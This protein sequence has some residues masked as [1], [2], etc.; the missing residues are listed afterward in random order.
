MIN[1][2]TI[3]EAF[4]ISSNP[5]QTK[6]I[7][8]SEFNSII[9]RALSSLFY[10]AINDY[11]VDQTWSEILGYFRREEDS[12]RTNNVFPFPNRSGKTELLEA[13]YGTDYNDVTIVSVSEWQDAR[14]RKLDGPTQE[15]PIAMLMNSGY[16]V[17]PIPNRVRYTFLK[18]PVDPIWGFTLSGTDYIY[19]PATSTDLEWPEA[20]LDRFVDRLIDFG[21]QVKRDVFLPSYKQIK[22]D[23][24]QP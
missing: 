15:Y 2:N 6:Y 17:E 16:K 5:G 11:Y 14:S 10:T 12:F 8:P 22:I 23:Q 3:Y 19:N 24:A 21:A 13:K 20:Q 18:R 1:I 9:K 7:A 4:K